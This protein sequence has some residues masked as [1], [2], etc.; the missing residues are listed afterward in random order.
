[1]IKQVAKSKKRTEYAFP[2]AVF[3]VVDGGD[4][5]RYPS[6]GTYRRAVYIATEKVCVKNCWL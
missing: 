5:Y 3:D 2:K 6:Q 4:A 1:M